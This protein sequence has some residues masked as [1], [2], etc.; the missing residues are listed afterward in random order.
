MDLD[1]F[2]IHRISPLIIGMI[3]GNVACIMLFDYINRK[4]K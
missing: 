2:I 1:F 4:S 3:L